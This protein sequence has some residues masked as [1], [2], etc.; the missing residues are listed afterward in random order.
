MSSSHNSSS[1]SPALSWVN[2]W[3]EDW[4]C[5]KLPFSGAARCDLACSRFAQ[6]V[7]CGE[8]GS[9]GKCWVDCCQRRSKA[10]MV[11]AGGFAAFAASGKGEIRQEDGSF[12]CF[13]RA[14]GKTAPKG[15]CPVMKVNPLLRVSNAPAF[16]T[17]YCGKHCNPLSS[18]L[19][20][21]IMQTWS[22]FG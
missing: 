18:T 8:S 3:G 16:S 13:L 15:R 7:I 10:R 17:L 12:N 11:T 6:A 1:F 14:T 2:F 5:Q 4:V 20:D 22:Q 9:C 21:T 19:S